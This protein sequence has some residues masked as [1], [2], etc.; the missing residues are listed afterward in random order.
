MLYEVYILRLLVLP[1][2]TMF[3]LRIGEGKQLSLFAREILLCI[4]SFG[5]QI[6]LI[7]EN[8]KCWCNVALEG[9]NA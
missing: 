4:F 6:Y 3:C 1:E 9:G 5:Q 7:G 8:D 2:L